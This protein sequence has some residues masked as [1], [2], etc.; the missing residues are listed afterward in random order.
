MTKATPGAA[1]P[2]A[3]PAGASLSPASASLPAAPDYHWLTGSFRDP[4]LERRFLDACEGHFVRR[5]RYVVAIIC[6]LECLLIGLDIHLLADY[7]EVLFWRLASRGTFILSLLIIIA[8][9]FNHLPIS[10]TSQYFFLFCMLSSN[11]VMASYHHP[12]LQGMATPGFLLAIY[13]F[14]ITAYYTFLSPWRLTLLVNALLFGLQFVLL[15]R[16]FDT[17]DTLFLYTPFLIFGL[18]SF[19]H[20]TA[21]S[22]ARQYRQVWLAAEEAKLRQHRAEEAQGFRAR[23]LELI[24]HDLRQPLS[25]L[26]Y[27]QTALRYQ[28]EA[29]E[30]RVA[31][32][33]VHLSGQID[34][35]NLQLSE[36]LTKALELA[37]LDY[38]AM[39]ARCLPQSIAP[40]AKDLR[41]QF[42]PLAT[43]EGIRLRLYGEDQHLMHDRALMAVVLRNLL[44][45]ALRYH[46]RAGPRPR[47]I[48]AFRR[49]GQRI[50]VIDNGGGMPTHFAAALDATQMRR[51]TDPGSSRRGL[52]L[53][54]VR[55]FAARQ[56]WQLELHNCPPSGVRAL[57]RYSQALPPPP[58]P[59][60][61]H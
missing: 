43:R 36:M 46:A 30:P 55:Q 41:H 26:G 2:K 15:Q 40:L 32:Q 38:D 17:S 12:A 20:Y 22:Q 52:G 21:V 10:R 11:S 28:A 49:D 31:S 33:L 34:Q 60:V 3:P 19:S 44:S 16:W 47:I 37:Q 27:Y 58:I 4:G 14:T 61:S 29:L 59:K 39:L 53:S 24:G 5:D 51:Q 35:I 23:L 18:I 54:I 45:N 6:C 8:F 42:A 7:P 48:L 56:G 9:I 25:A 50:E 1:W 57:L 13:I